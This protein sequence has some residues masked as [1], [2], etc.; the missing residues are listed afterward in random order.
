MTRAAFLDR[1]GTL[2]EDPGYLGDPG[3]VRLLTGVTEALQRLEAAGYLRI[4]ITN[5]SGIARG[6]ISAEQVAAV[7]REIQR[8]FALAGASID[9]WYTCPHAPG[10]GCDCRKPATG[11]HRA[12]AE[13]F[14]LDLSSS[15]VIGDRIGDVAPAAALG[16]KA[17]M[18]QTGE[19]QR[20]ELDARAAGIPVVAD[21][22]AAVDLLLAGRAD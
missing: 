17:V 6:L 12:A 2:I 22:S 11:S 14:G 1:D 13:R 19:G 4:V 15:W 7:H 20:H 3:Q 5:Q 9:A 8:Q 18:V 10:E 21:L 16:S